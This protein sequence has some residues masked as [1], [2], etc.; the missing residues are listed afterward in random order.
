MPRRHSL[1]HPE[2]APLAQGDPPPHT[3]NVSSPKEGV[4]EWG[5]EGWRGVWGGAVPF[6]GCGQGG[7]AGAGLGCTCT[8]LVLAQIA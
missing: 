2:P 4:G 7:V 1:P 3:V 8:P 5:E 6:I